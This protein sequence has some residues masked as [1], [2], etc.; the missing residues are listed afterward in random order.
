[1]AN[2]A[3]VAT[4]ISPEARA[5]A[6]NAATRQ[7][8]VMVPV[9]DAFTAGAT[10]RVLLPKVGLLSR[11]F[12]HFNGTLTVTVGGGSAAAASRGPW[13]I[14]NRIRL[15]ANSTL[16]LHDTSGFGAYFANLLSRWVGVFAR[17]GSFATAFTA[18]NAPQYE[19]PA[20]A[21][22]ARYSVANGANT[23]DF[24]I[25][26][27]VKLTEQDPIGLVIAQNPQTQLTVE[28]Q[29]GAV[30]DLVTLAGGAT[31]TLTGQWSI[32][33]E[34]FE[35]PANAGAMP[36][37][38]FVHVWQ[39][40]RVPV[41]AVGNNDI[42]LLTGDTYLRVGHVV[43]LNGVLNRADVNRLGLI[44]NAADQPYNL[45]RWL[46]LYR[47][48]RIYGKDLGDGLFVHDFFVPET[49]RD[50]INSALYSDL[51]SRVEIASTATLGVGN[52]FIDTVTEKLVQ[53][54]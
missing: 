22:V 44:F 2:A 7:K 6:F 30:A 24:S 8:F 10:Q 5:A 9:P 41:S 26:L 33:M 20:I 17:P 52:N 4:P 16:P 53:V 48:R 1:M 38:S 29:N 11:I 43:Q 27:P 31:A 19:P 54:A 46:Q 21:E 36:D 15:L 12:L 37:M 39:E 3:G 23:I 40:Q 14:A 34:Y 18:A 35:A 49:Q 51:R 47:Q 13:N 50:M 28:I 42:Q 25:E 32:G 45:D